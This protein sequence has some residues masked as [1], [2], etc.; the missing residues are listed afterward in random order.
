MEK[1]TWDIIKSSF[2]EAKVPREWKR[3]NLVPINK[4]GNKMESLNYITLR[5]TDDY[6]TKERN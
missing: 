5:W 1:L 4:G 3:D 2:K 6:F